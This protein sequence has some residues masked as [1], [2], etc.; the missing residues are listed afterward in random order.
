KCFAS[1]VRAA[2]LFAQLGM[3]PTA[4][5]WLVPLFRVLPGLLTLGAKLSGKTNGPDPTLGEVSYFGQGGC[6]A[7]AAHGVAAA[8]PPPNQ[9]T[10]GLGSPLTSARRLS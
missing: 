4:V 1:R 7:A 8:P 3:R 9:D 2:A 10:T 5:E 6:A